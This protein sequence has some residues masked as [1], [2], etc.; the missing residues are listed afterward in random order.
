MRITQPR[1]MSGAIRR[2][3]TL[4]ARTGGTM[5]DHRQCPGLEAM[6]STFFLLLSRAKA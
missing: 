1:H 2:F 6:V 5:P 3:T 4:P